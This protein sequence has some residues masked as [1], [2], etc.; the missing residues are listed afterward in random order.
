[1]S[2]DVAIELDREIAT[3]LKAT[4]GS[5]GP[6]GST[7]KGLS[8]V[9]DALKA[10]LASGRLTD[11]QYAKKAGDLLNILRDLIANDAKGTSR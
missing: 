4:A 9:H 10:E 5:N 8:K 7:V 11:A 3:A 1:M 2:G 6:L